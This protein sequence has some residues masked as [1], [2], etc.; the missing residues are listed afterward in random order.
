MSLAARAFAAKS[1]CRTA[2]VVARQANSDGVIDRARIAV[3]YLGHTGMTSEFDPHNP[4][5]SVLRSI[6]RIIDVLKDSPRVSGQ[7]LSDA[8]AVRTIRKEFYET[9]SDWTRKR[10]RGR[11][12]VYRQT[13]LRHLIRTVFAWILKE[14]G[15][16]PNVLFEESFARRYGGESYHRDVLM[17]MFH[18]RLNKSSQE[19]SR[20]H[21][22]AINKAMEEVTFLN[23]S[24]FAEHDGDAD[25]NLGVRHYFGVTET[26]PGLFTIMSRYDWTTHEHTPG[27]SDQTIDPEM[28]SNLF[29]NLFAATESE[30][31][32][33]T[34]PRGTYYTPS[35]VVAEMVKDALTAASGPFAPPV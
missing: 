25:L 14:G 20:H 28:L 5:R 33:K 15:I 2:V 32:Q 7:K 34:M 31:V 1:D 22:P 19:R 16:I 8:V 3:Q 26:D 29:E 17:F 10:Q 18:E 23:G 35:D 6:E 24:L 21:D 27:E 30:E 11:N 13:V 4:P 9:I 12:E